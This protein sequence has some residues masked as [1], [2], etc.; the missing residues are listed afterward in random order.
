MIPGL[1][2]S[3]GGSGGGLPF[4]EF[5]T[6]GQERANPVF[7][8]LDPLHYS[9]QI[10]S[11]MNA[12]NRLSIGGSTSDNGYKIRETTNINRIPARRDD[13]VVAR[14]VGKCEAINTVDCAAFKDPNFARDCIMTHAPGRNS[15][16]ESHLGGLASTEDEK[17]AQK[18]SQGGR[19]PN[20]KPIVGEAAEG[21]TSGDY[22][23]CIA[24]EEKIRCE[25]QQNFGVPNCGLC[26]NGQGMWTRIDPNADKVGPELLLAG[27]G[28]VTVL[29]VQTSKNLLQNRQLGAQAIPVDLPADSEGKSFEITVVGTAEEKPRIYGLLQGENGGGGTTT[30]DIAFIA[31]YDNA[32]QAKPRFIGGATI[33]NETL[34][35][36]TSA[37]GKNQISLTVNIPYTFLSSS[38]EA[39]A[40]CPGGPFSTK[41]ASVKLLG[42][43][44]CFDPNVPG[45]HSLQCL[46]DKFVQAGCSV[47][48]EGYPVNESMATQLR[49]VNGK[50]QT[51]G[52]ISDRIYKASQSASTGRSADGAKLGIEDWDAVSRFCTGKRITT[53]CSGYDMVNGPLGDECLQYLFENRGATKDEGQTYTV[54]QRHETLSSRGPFC[55]RDGTAA[56]YTPAA[57]ASARAAGGVENVKAYYDRI[58]RR[59][60]NNSLPDNERASAVSQC[61]GV[62]FA[63]APTASADTNP[64]R[65]APTTFSLQPANTQNYVRHA[66]F[67][68]WHQ[69]NAGTNLFKQDASFKAREPLCGKPG[70]MSL[71]AVNFP[72][73]FVANNGGR[74]QIMPREATPE[75]AERACW[76]A[77]SDCGLPG[78]ESYE[79]LFVPGAYMRAAPGSVT[80]VYIP[81]NDQERRAT[82]FKRTP[83]LNK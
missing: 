73:H 39:A 45:K 78:F 15:R 43:N 64:I 80:D 54:G 18:R 57:I 65:V 23:T 79:N 58:Q 1:I 12:T 55:T 61:Y 34:N 53:P 14:I 13:S 74:A 72:N 7:N 16:G 3:G 28:L 17:A 50:P 25:T 66:G 76:K 71:E 48:G 21:K 5:V 81:K 59:A 75:F 44:P 56:P 31:N 26:Q 20:Y 47:T 77:G 4:N 2:G 29:N 27:V 24:M 30:L 8:L 36:I 60:V 46:Q 37:V 70:Y 33:G 63:A 40:F 19:F 11:I 42:S 62:N 68:M 38:E 52:D 67:V 9:E 69:P 51:L 22:N 49:I 6:Y 83:P 41:E 10:G 82:C 35:V 32:A